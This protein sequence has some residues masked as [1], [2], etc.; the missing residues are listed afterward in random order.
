MIGAFG[1]RLFCRW[2]WRNPGRRFHRFAQA[3]LSSRYDL[4]AAAN[5]ATDPARAATFLLHAADEARHARAFHMRAKDLGYEAELQ[6]D[7]EHLYERLGEEKFLAFVYRGESRALKQFA[8]WRK[9]LG[10]GRDRTILEAVLPDEERHASY[11]YEWS[12]AKSRRRVGGWE[13]RRSWMRSGRAITGSLYTVVT[14][15][16]YL[17][18]APLAL[19]VR[20]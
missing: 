16:V 13:A 18:L 3:E 15:F 10:D 20:F 12:N 9:W 19:W 5:L 4:L 1:T 8:V 14:M 7:F 11:T 17:T 6:A 2:T